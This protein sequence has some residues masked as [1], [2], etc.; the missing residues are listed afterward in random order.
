MISLV[1]VPQSPPVAVTR[2]PV[3]GVFVQSFPV[4]VAK[5]KRK[6]NRYCHNWPI[7]YKKRED[8]VSEHGARSILIP[9]T[10]DPVSRFADSRESKQT[11]RQHCMSYLRLVGASYIVPEATHV[12]WRASLLSTVIRAGI[13]DVRVFARDLGSAVVLEGSR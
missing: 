7:P 4:L 5:Q 3:T 12:P 11:S 6:R 9:G 10:I 2:R 13:V 1:D 8:L